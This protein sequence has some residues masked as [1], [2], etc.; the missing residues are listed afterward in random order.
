MD[1]TDKDMEVLVYH[2]E[3]TAQKVNMNDNDKTKVD[4]KN[5]VDEIMTVFTTGIQSE[6]QERELLTENT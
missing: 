1:S 2:A 3:N 6:S 4:C 5:I